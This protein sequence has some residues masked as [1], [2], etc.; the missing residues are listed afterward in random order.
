[1]QPIFFS[2]SDNLTPVSFMNDKNI[3]DNKFIEM[4]DKLES[5]REKTDDYNLILHT[6]LILAKDY[7]PEAVKWLTLF[8]DAEW[9][10]EDLT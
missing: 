5:V 3:L 9:W 2:N 4:I 8:K 6:K 7:Y 1:M 10:K